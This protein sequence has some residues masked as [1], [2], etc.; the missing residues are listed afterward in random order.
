MPLNPQRRRVV[1]VSLAQK[2]EEQVE[3]AIVTNLG[4]LGCTGSVGQ[5]FMLLLAAHPNFTLHVVGA[6][7]RSAG[8]RYKDAVAWKQATAMPKRYEDMIVKECVPGEFAEC[9]LVFSGLDADVAGEI[10]GYNP[11]YCFLLSRSRARVLAILGIRADKTST[12]QRQPLCKPIFLYSRMPKT[13]AMI[14]TFP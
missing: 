4:V 7:A 13:I 9:D 14:L 12:L 10:G 1:S 6:S 5:R 11:F 8:K 3:W 2:G